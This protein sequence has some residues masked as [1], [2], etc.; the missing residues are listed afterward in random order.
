MFALSPSQTLTL[1]LISAAILALAFALSVAKHH[2]IPN[3]IFSLARALASFAATWLIWGSL[4]GSGNET[5]ATT[6]IGLIPY[7]TLEY[8]KPA[9][10]W[11]AQ[12]SLHWGALSLSIALTGLVLFILSFALG[13]L[14]AI[15]DR[16]R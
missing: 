9:E 15:S 8:T 7:L 3:P 5:T 11:M 1:T 6:Q 14:A 2:R 13:H 10:H 4:V 12:A 16:R